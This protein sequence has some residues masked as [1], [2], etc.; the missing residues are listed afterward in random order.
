MTAPDSPQSE[1]GPVMMSATDMWR[2]ANSASFELR[3]VMLRLS[4][5]HQRDTAA[6]MKAL[7]RARAILGDGL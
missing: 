7:A 6:A 1:I 4:S 5:P 3:T 2:M